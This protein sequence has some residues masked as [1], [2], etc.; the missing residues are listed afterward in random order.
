MEVFWQRVQA[1]RRQWRERLVTDEAG[2]LLGGLVAVLLLLGLGL[3]WYWGR[4][5]ARLSIVTVSPATSPG[6]VLADTLVRVGDTLLEKPGGYLRNDFLPPGVWSDNMAA[7]E[8]GVLQQLRDLTQLLHRHIALSRA[9]Y[10]EDPDLARADA[11]FQFDAES[12]L[13]PSSEGEYRGAIAAVHRYDERLQA[14]KGEA[15]FDTR[16][17]YL[18]IWLSDVD[19]RLG[20]LSSRLNAALPSYRVAIAGKGQVTE[21]H[22]ETPWSQIDDVFYE[23]RGSAW[24]LLHFLKAV[25]IEFAPELQRAHAVLSLRAAIHELEATQETVWSPLIL[26]GSGFGFTAN[27]SL[28]MANYLNRAQSDLRDVRQLLKD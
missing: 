8:L 13:L 17:E 18:V 3:G 10:L 14:G 26:N 27:H 20:N 23:S 5:P 28:V 12:W 25:E 2:W 19:A 15:L 4:E 1:W 9:Q 22:E 6:H 24:A 16:A 21:Q 11:G 7:W